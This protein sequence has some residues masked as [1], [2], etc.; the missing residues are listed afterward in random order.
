M[1]MA[2]RANI[3]YDVGL[4]LYIA[5]NLIC[6]EYR[7]QEEVMIA[8]QHLSTTVSTCTPLVQTLEKA[9]CEDTDDGELL[10]GREVQLSQSDED[11]SCGRVAV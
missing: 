4:A 5:E 1:S 11:V 6:F 9:G 3:Q 7:L 2:Q 8:V 10:A